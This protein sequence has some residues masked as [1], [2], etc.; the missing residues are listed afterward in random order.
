MTIRLDTLLRVMTTN[1]SFSCFTTVF[2]SYYRQ[3]W[4]SMEIYDDSKTRYMFES[5][6]QNYLFSRFTIVFMSYC[7]Q[8]WGSGQFALPIRLDICLRYLTKNSSF[9][10]WWPFFSWP[11]CHSFGVPVRFTTTVRPDTCLRDKTKISSFSCFMVVFM[12]Y[13]PRFLGF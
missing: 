5:Y 8:F 10:V 3:F 7:P 1:W 6:D 12:R 4:R 2:M 13:C 11:M 9:P